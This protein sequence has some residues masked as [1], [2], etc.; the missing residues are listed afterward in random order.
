ML[1][2]AGFASQVLDSLDEENLVH[3]VKLQTALGQAVGSI[4]QGCLDKSAEAFE[5]ALGVSLVCGQS[6][7]C[8]IVSSST[9]R[10]F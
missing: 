8:V 4:Y 6:E 10:Q 9:L 1:R 5:H 7:T 3:L 2:I